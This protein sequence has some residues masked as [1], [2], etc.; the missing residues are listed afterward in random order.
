[1][2]NI[3]EDLSLL[4]S[5]EK[6][7]VHAPSPKRMSKWLYLGIKLFIVLFLLPCDGHIISVL[8][9]YWS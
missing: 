1:M 5:L 6:W 7:L 8:G 4:S 2:D 3:H 9:T